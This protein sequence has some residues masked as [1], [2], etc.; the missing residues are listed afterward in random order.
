MEYGRFWREWERAIAKVSRMKV[1]MR[2]HARVSCLNAMKANGKYEEKRNETNRQQ[3]E[4][5]LIANGKR[6]DGGGWCWSAVR[7]FYFAHFK[8]IHDPM[9]TTTNLQSEKQQYALK[10]KSPIA[11]GWQI[12][13]HVAS[14]ADADFIRRCRTD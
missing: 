10:L 7:L 6:M 2:R 8:T 14:R 12:L 13:F 11:N 1:T 9:T 4:K 5:Q 3:H